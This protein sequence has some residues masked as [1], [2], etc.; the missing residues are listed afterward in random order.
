M[1][2]KWIRVALAALLVL[3]MVAPIVPKTQAASTMSVSADLIRVLKKMEGF[4]DYSAKGERN[5]DT[6][7]ILA[8]PASEHIY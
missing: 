4:T 6:E 5:L 8:C 3:A 2:N 1:K 7:M